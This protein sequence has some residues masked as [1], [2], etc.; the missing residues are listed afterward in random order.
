MASDKPWSRSS[1]RS[2]PAEQQPVYADPQAAERSLAELANR[3]PLVAAGEVERLRRLLGEAASG[4]R[5]V[6]QGGDCAETFDGCTE[7]SLRSK[8]EV[9]LQMS[10]VLTYATRKPVVRI[11]RIA[12]QYAKPRSNNT[13]NVGGVELPSYR[14]DIVNGAEPNMAARTPDPRRLLTAY[15]HAA[16]SLNYLRALIEGGFA[17]L[18]HPQRW[19]LDLV[20]ASPRRAAYER[21]MFAITDAIE[22]MESIGASS[23][24][25]LQ[26]IELFTSHEALL[27]PWEEALTRSVSGAG[28]YN[29]SAHCL[30]LG[31]RTCQLDGAHVE[32]MR[33]IRNPIAIKVGTGTTPHAL[34]QL[35]S[36]LDPAREPGRVT[37]ISRLGAAAV[38]DRLPPLIRAV[39]ALEHPVLWS[40]DPMHGNTETTPSGRKT[41]RLDAIFGELEQTFA[42][43]ARESSRLGGVHFEMTG[44]N[45]T[46]CLGGSIEVREDDLDRSYETAC[47]PRLNGSQAL[48]MAFRIAELLRA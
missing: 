11:A 4:Q 9:L 26:R 37:L 38:E 7:V 19:A 6:L 40:C 39:Q 8:L 48:E 30:W 14:G 10:L 46:E 35:L 17:D 44:E 43:H 20:S 2:R 32:Y 41:R 29:L 42:V 34:G 45:V 12:G 47:D 18:R 3:P 15:G 25:A 24:A 33:G 27:L 31:Y 22:L 16:A 21:T 1:W 23:Q 5:F 36:R 28:D 13:E